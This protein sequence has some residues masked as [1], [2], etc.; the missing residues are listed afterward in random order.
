VWAGAQ[1]FFS[2][3]A[4]GSLL[5]DKDGTVR[6]STLLA[7]NF[8]DAKYFHPRPSA[9]GTGYD[10]T[11]SSGTNLGPTSQK[12]AD[13]IKAAVTAYR[14]ENALPDT[15][16]VPADAVTSSGSGLDPHI[17]VANAQLQA[18]R[19][20]RARRLPLNRVLSLITKDTDARSWGVFGETGVN[21]LLL[22]RDLDRETANQ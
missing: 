21:V 11:S 8:A 12:L 18:P 20:A 7:Q 3:Q 5:I 14:T 10:A 22:N 6:G 1:A 16:S 4:N 15:N 13:S 2:H 9:A 17:S 19:V